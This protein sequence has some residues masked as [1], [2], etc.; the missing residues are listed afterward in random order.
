MAA[1]T[2]FHKIYAD[3]FLQKLDEYPRCYTHE[4]ASP[5]LVSEAD[6]R[7]S[8]PQQ[9]QWVKREPSANFDNIAH[10]MEIELHSDVN[11]FY[12]HFYAGTLQFDSPWGEG[13]L[14]QP[15]NEDDFFL[16]QQ[17]V[18]GHLMM[19][20]QLKQPATWFIG[21][22][23]DNEEMLTVNNA[24]GSVWK[25]VAG[26]E[27]HEKLADSLAAFIGQLHGRVAPPMLHQDVAPMVTEHPGIIAS[28]KRMWRNLLGR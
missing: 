14:I 18:L 26:N 22:I 17:N 8:E 13:E 28:M 15:W 5:C 4:R 6:S 24:D 25:E 11:D 9:W 20:K 7:A 3:A 2:N 12:G 10:A 1:L 21:L 27:P 23:G 16:L 19:K